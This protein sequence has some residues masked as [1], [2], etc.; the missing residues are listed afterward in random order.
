[1]SRKSIYIISIA[2]MMVLTTCLLQAFGKDIAAPKANTAPPPAAAQKKSVTDA[3]V[4]STAYYDLN[5]RDCF[6]R[7]DWN[8]AKRLLDE[9][10]VKY[11]QMSAFHEGMGRYYLHLAQTQKNNAKQASA[12]YDKARYYLI[13]AINIDEKNVQARHYML[14]VE[15]ETK[16]YSTAIVYCNDL[17]E[18]NPYNENLWRKKIDLYRKLGNNEEADRLLE[19][20]STIYPE[21]DQFKKDLT[22]RCTVKAKAQRDNGD[23]K[24]QEQTLRQLLEIDPRNSDAHRALTNLLYRQ[25]R[26]AEAAEAA[27]QGFAM[28]GRSEFV[29][30]R[31]GMLCEMNRHREA[32]EYVKLLAK[33]NAS[34]SSLL[35]QLELE[36]ARAAQ[37]N[38][39]YT[40]YAKIYE[41]QH[42]GEALDYLV[43][44]S[45]ERWYLDDA[46]M[47]VEEA[48]RVKGETPQM[49]Y[50]EYLVN[51]RLGNTRKAN[52][53]LE[54]L[55]SKYPNN[56]DIAEEM[57]LVYMDRAKELIADEQYHEAIPLLEKTFNSN[58]YPYLREAAFQRLYNC[59]YQTKQYAKAEAM[60]NHLEGTSRITQTA[61][62]YNAWGK[63]KKALDFLANSFESAD[64]TDAETRDIIAYTYEDIA[65]P[66][67][68]NLLNNNRVREASRQI[69]EAIDIC[70]NNDDMIRYGI[71]AA[72]RMGD[73]LT[74]SRYVNIGLRQNPDDP[75]YI[76]KHA[77]LSHNSG[78]N[79]A[80][81]K[82]IAPLLEEY[83][84]DSMLIALFVESNIEKAKQYMHE[85]NPDE[86]LRVL[87]TAIDLDPN[88]S[89]LYYLQGQA[90]E[91]KKYWDLAYESY[92]KYK[93]GYAELAEYNHHL[94]ELSR[95][96]LKNSLSLEYQQARPGSED[97]ISGNAYLNYTH[98]CDTAN[99]FN[100]GLAYAGRDGAVQ[101]G[102]TEMTRGGTGIQLSG[103]YEHQFTN[104]ITGKVEAA[105]ANRYFPIVMARLSGTYD[106]NNDWQAS[107]FASYRL[108]RSYA[109][110]YGWQSEIV[111]YD[112]ANKPI[113]GNPQYIRT[114][115]EE[116]KKSMWQLGAGVTKTLDKFV[117]GGGVS[118]L[119][120]DKK[121]YFNSNV[122][123][124][125]F[126]MD[127][128][129][130]NIFAVGGVGTAP[131]SSL[132]DR[133]MPVGFN[134]VNTFVG[135][136]GSYFLNR[137][138][139][140]GLSGTWYTMLSQ[141]ER[142]TTTYIA[143]DPFVKEDYR[144][145]F[146]AHGS[147]TIHF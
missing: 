106:F 2:I 31:V 70:P 10:I 96:T 99:A 5:I 47:Y 142:L 40:S 32:V 3:P 120:F 18:E 65:L 71:T 116:S 147:V 103:G 42:S 98:V 145:Y 118:G 68:K 54:N 44:T 77:Q 64:E 24:G 1:M 7:S 41:S 119:Y 110:T 125:F 115:W 88:N 14:Q 30:K 60:L 13:R 91:Q 73:T 131:E 141:S 108:L 97:V 28:T 53:L 134:K 137:W 57:M 146:Y 90:Y 85:K 89:E 59:Y 19:R 136:G 143:N 80:A 81:L 122:K 38:D 113:Y 133:S 124:Q 114:G 58:T 29:E 39:A 112:G 92:R 21:N 82:E 43:S 6:K 105:V 34:Y 111:G 132:I 23:V 144:N 52:T 62:L 12:S 26:I 123:M 135:I 20:I 94:E 48:L 76:L 16:H 130:S 79:D 129:T 69:E 107:A 35:S 138:I 126:P 83:A 49:L 66:Y 22:E 84:G 86:A 127:G 102:D 74:V 101:Q 27:G 63:P 109:G 55:Y 128:N 51:K 67:V 8:G 50:N 37:Y 9:A 17:L 93:P 56:E 11:P 87:S 100:V 75:Y 95:H 104:R 72:Q 46:L 4:G 121:L 117:L 45:I 139:T 25:G 36:A 78:N 140:L 61:M 33:S 15:T